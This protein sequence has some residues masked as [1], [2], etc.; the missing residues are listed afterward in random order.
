MHRRFALDS[1][2]ILTTVAFKFVTSE[3]TPKTPYMTFLDQFMLIGVLIL[4]VVLVKDFAVAMLFQQMVLGEL[5]EAEAMGGSGYG[6]MISTP[7][8][9][10]DNVDY[11]FSAIVASVWTFIVLLVVVCGSRIFRESWHDVVRKS[12]V[13]MDSWIQESILSGEL[14][15]NQGRGHGHGHGHDQEKNEKKEKTKVHGHGHSHGNEK[16][17]KKKVHGHGHS[18]A[19]EKK[20]KKKEHGHGHSH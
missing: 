5:G 19:H 17:E 2:L 3:M 9:N 10:A 20:E 18:H 12:E 11:Y 8:F 13:E 6:A 14:E 16:K 7:S 4:M 1:T 15:P